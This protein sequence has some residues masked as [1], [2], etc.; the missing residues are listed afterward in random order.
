MR[1][2]TGHLTAQALRLGEVE[3]YFSPFARLTLSVADGGAYRVSG[4]RRPDGKFTDPFGPSD[5]IGSIHVNVFFRRLTDAR[6]FV[7][8]AV[9]TGEAGPAS[10]PRA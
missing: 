7:V 3:P 6:R 1:T 2:K 5:G 10:Q 8:N 9:L 4:F